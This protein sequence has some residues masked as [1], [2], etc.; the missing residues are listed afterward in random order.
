MLPEASGAQTNTLVRPKETYSGDL[1][2]F[3]DSSKYDSSQ[4]R[5]QSN[6]I[7]TQPGSARTEWRRAGFCRALPESQ[8][9]GVFRVLADDEEYFGGGRPY[10][11]SVLAGVS[12]REFVPRRLRFF[13][14]VV[15]GS[16]EHSADEAAPAEVSADRFS[17]RAGVA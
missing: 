17:R 15:P 3:H 9:A 1:R 14:M 16:R 12:K 7:R 8:K 10:A 4:R 11:R 13:H 5:V 2:N 6:R